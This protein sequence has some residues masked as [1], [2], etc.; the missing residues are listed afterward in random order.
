[1]CA[2]LSAAGELAHF[3]T[4]GQ[5][6]LTSPVAP[7]V[8]ARRE[9]E[10]PVAAAVAPQHHRLGIMLAYTPLHHLLFDVGRA[11]GLQTLVMTS[12][13]DVDEPLVYD[14]SQA[15]ARL[16]QMCDA[17]LLHNRPIERALDDSVVIDAGN[18]ILPLRRAR[19]LAPEPLNVAPFSGGACPACLDGDFLSHAAATR[20]A[21][22]AAKYIAPRSAGPGPR[23]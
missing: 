3:T 2:S 17:L 21:S 18:G 6:A 15:V 23:R 9:L 11:M 14:D 12:A 1:M 19:G 13:N 7:I 22:S 16:G 20:G 8:L 4:A 10:P 5:A